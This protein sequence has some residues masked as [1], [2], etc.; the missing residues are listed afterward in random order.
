MTIVM[1]TAAAAR[2]LADIAAA[3]QELDA[4]RAAAAQRVEHLRARWHG[5]AAESFAAAH[6][7]WAA[8]A[9]EVRAQL[10][11]LRDGVAHAQAT[12]A[13]LDTS[14]ASG[15]AHLAARLG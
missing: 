15:L 10:E 8:A 12:L 11:S 2:G 13:D 6:E 4:A 7:A 1:G 14:T 3:T 5:Q 9:G